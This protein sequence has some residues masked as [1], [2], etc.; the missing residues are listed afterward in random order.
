[1]ASSFTNV[2]A[3]QTV[4]LVRPRLPFKLNKVKSTSLRD[5]AS[6]VE[7]DELRLLL[8]L[9]PSFARL[10][11]PSMANRNPVASREM[12]FVSAL[13]FRRGIHFRRIHYF[14][15]DFA[16]LPT[17]NWRW[18]RNSRCIHRRKL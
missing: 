9:A 17:G 7:E 12:L 4:K 1:M 13:V 15:E 18:F 8:F 6:A 11:L 5:H 3:V 2:A 16:L 10:R 14:R